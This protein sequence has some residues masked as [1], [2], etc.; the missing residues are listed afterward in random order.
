M[1]VSGLT[2]WLLLCVAYASANMYFQNLAN[3]L[4]KT[5]F[6]LLVMGAAIYAVAAAIAWIMTTIV[7]MVRHSVPVPASVPRTVAVEVP[8]RPQ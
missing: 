4:A 1:F 7:T 3:R 5:P 6:K 8:T 2:G